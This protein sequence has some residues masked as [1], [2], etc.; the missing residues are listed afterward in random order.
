[1]TQPLWLL[2]ASIVLGFV[3]IIWAANA[4]TR[5]RGLEYNA[6]ARDDEK[7]RLFGVPGRLE[8]ASKNFLETFAFFAA[9]VLIA[10][11]A[12]RNNSLT[13]VGAH[14]YFWAR[15]VYLPVYVAGTPYIRSGIWLVSAIGIFAILLG[16]FLP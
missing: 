10:H 6:S 16:L 11:V 8:R 5:V 3:H 2:V 13:V 1:M 7:P 9:A 14:L 15:V 12:N 4:A